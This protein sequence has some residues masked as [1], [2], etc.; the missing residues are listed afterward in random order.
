[1]ALS[2]VALA[3]VAVPAFAIVGGG[4]D[5]QEVESTDLAGADDRDERD[6]APETGAVA[7]TTS[8]T[9]TTVP[10]TE[11]AGVV[12]TQVPEEPVVTAPPPPPTAPPLVCEN[13]YDPAC[14]PRT[15]TY[16]PGPNAPL[17]LTAPQ[18]LDVAPGETVAVEV[19]FDD[20]DAPLEWQVGNAHLRSVGG[21]L[22]TFVASA[23]SFERRYGPW[24]PPP[25]SRGSGT[26]TYSYTAPA[27]AVPGDV[28]VI[29]ISAASASTPYCDDPY[30]SEA[31]LEVRVPVVEPAG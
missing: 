13:S 17:L 4:E 1:V 5:P 12:I 16:D 24:S 10:G 21:D 6:E 15:W 18:G 29:G 28:V 7:T 14:G 20:P 23:C 3:L 27:D 22:P 11:V 25:V 26:F 19:S 9:A 30:R 31:Q 2:G 8:T